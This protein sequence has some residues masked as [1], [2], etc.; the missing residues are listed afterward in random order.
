MKGISRYWVLILTGFALVSCDDVVVSPII[1]DGAEVLFDNYGIR[2]TGPRLVPQHPELLM[3]REEYYNPDSP[4][5]PAEDYTAYISTYNFDTGEITRVLGGDRYYG[6]GDVSPNG[7]RIVY[8]YMGDLYLETYPP[9]GNPVL[10]VDSG[11][12]RNSHWFSNNYQI[13]YPDVTGPAG[14]NLHLLNINTF[15]DNVIYEQSEP[16]TVYGLISPTGIL[17]VLNKDYQFE[18]EM[19]AWTELYKWDG[20]QLVYERDLFD[21]TSGFL[22]PWVWSPDGTELLVEGYR[23]FKNPHF[24]D[25]ALYIYDIETG[26]VTQLTFT[27]RSRDMGISGGCWSYD[28]SKVYFSTSE[29]IYVIDV[30]E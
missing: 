10:L 24:S 3:F 23:D 27:D 5:D 26:D 9:E 11:V 22:Y 7:S 12:L 30:P 17:F 20:E 8:G 6:R 15:E 18:H 29:Q 2:E 1:E 14:P 4:H 16:M 28:G 13:L 25:T 21:Y 19:R